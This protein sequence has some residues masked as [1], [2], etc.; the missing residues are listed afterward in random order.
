MIVLIILL[1]LQNKGNPFF[2]QERPG[3][4]ASP[5]QILKFKTM[6]DEKDENG[7]LL[8]DNKR[9]TKLG[10]LIRKT[11][12]DELPQMINVM[13]GDMSLVGPRPLLFKYLNLY[14]KEQFRR[15]EV[16]PGITGWAQ[17]NGRNNIA[18]SEKFEFDVFYVD[19]LSF[20]LDIKILW[21]TFLKVLKKEGVNQSDERPMQPFNGKN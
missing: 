8:P 3:K 21:M 12:L 11:S 13:K 17:V 7:N 16:L 1:Y 18:W 5:F 20:L 4:D 14:S 2:I 10:D 9:I 15:H 19:H 6:T